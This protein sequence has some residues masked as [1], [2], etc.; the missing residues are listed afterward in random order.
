MASV[1][2]DAMYDVTFLQQR[3][4]VVEGESP[5]APTLPALPLAPG[6]EAYVLRV[7]LQP[8]GVPAGYDLG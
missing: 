2:P 6:E 3:P 7:C 5:F 1:P 8:L 4:H